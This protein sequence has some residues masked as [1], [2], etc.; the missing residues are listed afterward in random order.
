MHLTSLVSRDSV[1]HETPGAEKLMV[2]IN[3][4]SHEITP[5][6]LAHNNIV[7]E[8]T[9]TRKADRIQAAPTHALYSLSRRDR[10]GDDKPKPRSL[11]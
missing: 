5:N 1:G 3:S 9:T 10:A 8:P 4:H 11:G 6:A 2:K 7:E